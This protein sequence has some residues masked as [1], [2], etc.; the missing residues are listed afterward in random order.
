MQDCVL[1]NNYASFTGGGAGGYC[2]L[3]NC[4]LAGNHAREGGGAYNVILSNCVLS[5]NFAELGAGV[6][7][8]TLYQC[9]LIENQATYG[10]GAYDSTLEECEVRGNTADSGGGVNQCNLSRCVVTRNVAWSEQTEDGGYGGGASDS[11]LTDCVVSLNFSADDGGGVVWSSLTNCLV[12]DNLAAMGGGCSGSELVGCTVVGNYAAIDGG[13][14]FEGWNLNTIVIHNMSGIGNG[15]N[16]S[17]GTFEFSCTLPFPSEGLGNITNTPLFLNMADGNF[18]L[19]P[20]SPC[21]NA[22]RNATSPAGLDLD[23]L[24]RVTGGTVDIGAYEFQTPQS[25]ISY[26]WLQQHG[27]PNDGSADHSDIDGDRSSNEQEWRAGTDPT[28]AAS[29]FK[30]HAL[31]RTPAGLVVSWESVDGRT[32][33]LER[34]VDPMGLEFVPWLD[35][36]P[37]QPGTT[38]HT[39][40]N[41][42]AAGAIIYRVGVKQ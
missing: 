38:S 17:I 6:Y 24:P 41:N 7:D 35:Q 19:Q 36:I 3:T 2:M 32:Y 26:A 34:S 16:H 29:V 30:L 10:G 18:H 9:S 15:S 28:N 23:G 12:T 14:T 20:D 27:L 8:S 40:T 39:D 13:G 31:V 4:F 42:N 11:I 1:L 21:I 22:G 33:Y 37:G 5:N 25:T